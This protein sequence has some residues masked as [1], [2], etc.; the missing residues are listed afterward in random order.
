MKKPAI[1][2]LCLLALVVTPLWADE[3]DITT[4]SPGGWTLS[5][6][7]V[8]VSTLSSETHGITSYDSPQTAPIYPVVFGFTFSFTT[9]TLASVDATGWH[10]G[11]GGSICVYSSS[12]F[13]GDPTPGNTLFQGTF[14]GASLVQ[15]GSGFT[16]SS[17]FVGGDVSLWLL[18]ALGIGDPTTSVEG[19]LTS[20][21]A[22]GPP[23]NFGP[24]AQ[25]STSG[26]TA[27][28]HQ[29]NKVPEP[30][31]MVLLGTGMLGFGSLVR[32]KLNL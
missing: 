19:S 16:F 28:L 22:N 7:G 3:V 14:T 30:A 25:G 31:S 23:L 5:P 13:C 17:A 11:A 4:T 24:G 10:F 20:A 29:F 27:N 18:W 26:I 1:L 2:S 12:S 6:G 15:Q 32:R 21:F 8:G 9:G